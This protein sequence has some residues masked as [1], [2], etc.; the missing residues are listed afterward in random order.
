M[1]AFTLNTAQGHIITLFI[2][3]VNLSV[4]PRNY[5]IRVRLQVRLNA[6]K[7]IQ[8]KCGYWLYI[9]T[10]LEGHFI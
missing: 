7:V 2:W 9:Y 1:F 3:Y 10:M 6:A 4:N 5:I 8:Q